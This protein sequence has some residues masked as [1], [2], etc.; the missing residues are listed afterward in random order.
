MAAIRDDTSIA[1][2]PASS[3]LSIAPTTHTVANTV[4]TTG[5]T[6]ISIAGDTQSLQQSVLDTSVAFA[7][8]SIGD[9]LSEFQDS[10]QGPPT[11][12]PSYVPQLPAEVPQPE[13][14]TEQ[15]PPLEATPQPESPIPNP[16][17]NNYYCD[18]DPSPPMPTMK[19]KQDDDTATDSDI[20]RP[21]KKQQRFNDFFE[22]TKGLGKGPHSGSGRGQGYGR[23]SLHHYFPPKTQLSS[24][25]L[26]AS[27]VLEVTTAV[28]PQPPVAYIPK[29]KSPAPQRYHCLGSHSPGPA[30]PS[31]SPA[32]AAHFHPGTDL[33]PEQH[34]L[35]QSPLPEDRS[36]SPANPPQ[37][38]Q[39]PKVPQG[40]DK[41]PTKVP[42]L[43]KVLGDSLNQDPKL[44]HLSDKDKEAVQTALNLALASFLNDGPPLPTQLA[45][46]AMTHQEAQSM[47]TQDTIL[48]NK[49][50]KTST[51][52]FK[53]VAVKA[54]AVATP[55]SAQPLPRCNAPPS[56]RILQAPPPTMTTLLKTQQPWRKTQPRIHKQTSQTY[57]PD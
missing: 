39:P 55:G 53:P 26:K 17:S 46:P 49:A 43:M 5:P 38:P 15:P 20:K 22:S 37:D 19:H 50:F 13:T 54:P 42:A 45:I 2:A 7:A 32:Y 52:V 1:S 44:Q 48:E 31:P 40:E 27:K 14:S 10:V 4:T 33:T 47:V 57:K 18:L 29:K 34:A 56:L 35:L 51:T 36:P 11:L 30:Y 16:N 8:I 23:G 25:G 41:S 28:E 6:A 9:D 24:L 12:D 21:S 3:L